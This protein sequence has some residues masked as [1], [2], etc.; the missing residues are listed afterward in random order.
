[1]DVYFLEGEDLSW[2][3]GVI[4]TAQRE[5]QYLRVAVDGGV[6]ISRGQS[7]W[8]PPLGRKN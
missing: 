5:G 7:M 4:E 8:T 6:K 2:L 3:A 1:M